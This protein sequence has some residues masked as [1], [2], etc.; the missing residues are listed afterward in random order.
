LRYELA[1]LQRDLRALASSVGA[2]GVLAAPFAPVAVLQEQAYA[3]L[4]RWVCGRPVVPLTAK[5][6]ARELANA[7]TDLRGVVPRLADR[8]REI[9]TLR[10]A[11]L[12]H[13]QP[14]PGLAA[15]LAALLPTDFLGATPFPQLAHL[16]RYLR[17]MKMRADRWKQDP[18]RDARRAQQLAPY[19]EAVRA[20]LRQPL[21]AEEVSR[22]R[23]LVEELR[24]GLFAQELGTAERVS[25]VKLDRELAALRCSASPLG[26]ATESAG[27]DATRSSQAPVAAPPASGPIKNLGALDRLFPRV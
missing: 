5:A 9:F 7:R 8:L 15:D 19:V 12:T 20:L 2:L 6:F 21:P 3:S 4:R 25:A 22:F 13:P 10:Q 23:W 11:L 16:P 17:S 26:S 27:R 24:V 14:Y 18:A 1:W